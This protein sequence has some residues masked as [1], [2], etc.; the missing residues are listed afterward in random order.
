MDGLTASDAPAPV[1][2]G[3]GTCGGGICTLAI[4]VLGFYLSTP[5][6][7]LHICQGCGR[8]L[9]YLLVHL[10]VE[11]RKIIVKPQKLRFIH[12]QDCPPDCRLSLNRNIFRITVFNSVLVRFISQ[13]AG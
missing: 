3:E 2:S 13:H 5:G 1:D 11:L 12:S 6:R 8:L 7:L 4:P 10:P 9:Q